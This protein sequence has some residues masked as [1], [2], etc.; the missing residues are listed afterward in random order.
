MKWKHTLVLVGIFAVFL[1]YVLIFQR[2]E[3]PKREQVFRI[4]PDK[5]ARLEIDY[6][7]EEGEDSREDVVL[8][9]RGDEWY[10]TK[11]VEGL[12]DNSAVEQLL[13]DFATLEAQSRFTA[14]DAEE[15]FREH[16]DELGLEKPDAIIQGFDAKGRLLA[17]VQIGGKVKIGSDLYALAD[18]QLILVSTWNADSLRKKT[19]DLRDKHLT[20]F[21]ADEV[22]QLILDYKDRSL[23]LERVS[24]EEWRLIKPVE[25]KADKYN[26]DDL[27][28]VVEQL[29]AKD[30]LEKEEGKTDEDYG[31]AKPQIRVTVG[32]KD[33]KKQVVLLGK[34]KEDAAE[35]VVYAKVEGRDEILLA[36]ASAITDLQK[37]MM[38]LRETSMVSMSTSDVERLT[39]NYKGTTY[40]LNK[41]ESE[42][43]G[44]DWLMEQPQEGEAEYSAVDDIVWAATGLAAEKFV[45]EH[46]TSLKPF[47]LD[48]PQ[49]TIT[50]DGDKQSVTI[51]IGKAGGEEGQVHARSSEQEAVAL[52]NDDIL[53]DLPEKPEDLLKKEEPESTEDEAPPP[54][55]EPEAADDSG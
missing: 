52:V 18:D 29:E 53:E 25:A 50:L 7:Q 34:K 41:K 30:F 8:E 23:G 20:H 40:V 9:K 10:L 13:K 2:G 46:P 21:T 5:L 27:L 47:G 6:K 37:D 17:K 22:E 26:C 42:D 55:N 3:P 48:K 24:E 12:A 1:G 44:T 54:G 4:N 51:T 11:P 38:D 31:L 33:D 49:A 36:D 28:R 32:L 39:V 15:M 16:A 14:A 35:E 19:L 43:G 45:V